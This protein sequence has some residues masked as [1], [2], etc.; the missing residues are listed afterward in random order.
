MGR[1]PDFGARPTCHGSRPMGADVAMNCQ[2]LTRG[3]FG[4]GVVAGFLAFAGPL[5]GHARAQE[6][7]S[8]DDG[9]RLATTWCSGCH[10]V[11][12][13]PEGAAN[14]AAPSFQ[15]VGQRS[16]TTM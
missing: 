15:S 1:F 10:T 13:A 12:A 14:D 11:G 7:G 5:L 6:L 3:L 8:V 2:G 16:S 4:R 9:R